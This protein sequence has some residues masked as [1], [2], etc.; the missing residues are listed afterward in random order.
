M[1]KSKTGITVIDSIPDLQG[2]IR[3]RDERTGK[4]YLISKD[5]LRQERKRG[6]HQCFG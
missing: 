5:Q 3:V 2:L 6:N 4:T 1:N